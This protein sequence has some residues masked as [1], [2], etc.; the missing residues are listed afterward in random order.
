MSD[1]E[2]RMSLELSA[3]PTAGRERFQAE[4]GAD[5]A[6]MARMDAYLALLA[7]WNER[8]NLVGPSAL[9]EFW[10]RHALDSAQLLRHAPD[11]RVW[12]DIGAGA[13]FPGLVLAILLQG[14]PGVTV[15]LIESM[16]KRCTFLRAVSTALNLPTRVHNA[17]AESLDL[18]PVDV[19]TARAC[20][21]LPR[22]LE[23]ARPLV[24]GSAVALFLKG[25]EAETEL[26]EARKTWRFTASLLPSISGAE[27]RIIRLERLTR[28]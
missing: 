1:V 14:R 13:G 16:T 3:L 21:P 15:H 18:S 11:A 19:V 5:P 7:E 17:R 26:A 9:A 6:A 12:A 20:A 28:V 2:H 23:Y 27:G 10:E 25:R 4:T 24:R 22:L 8:M